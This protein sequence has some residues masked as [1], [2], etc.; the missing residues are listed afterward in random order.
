M[1]RKRQN[2]ISLIFILGFMG[3]APKS[4]S[5]VFN[6]KMPNLQSKTQWVDSIMNQ[7]TIDQKIGQLMM[8]R[9]HSDKSPAYEN[10]VANLV[11]NFQ[12][13]GICFFQGTPAKQ[14]A[15]TNYYQSLAN[16]P[17]MIGM[18]AEWGLGMRLTDSVMSFPKSLTLGAIKNNALIKD[19]GKEIAV[20]LKRIGVHVNFAPVADINNNPENPVINVRSFGENRENVATKATAYMQGLQENGIMACAKHFPGHGDTNIDSHFE[21]PVL[22]QTFDRLDSLELFPF[23]TLISQGIQSVM[24]GHLNVPSIESKENIPTSLSPKA[25]N[26]LLINKM[27]FKGLVFTDGLEMKGVSQLYK[28]GEIEAEALIAGNDVLLLPSNVSVAL[29]TI[30]NYMAR[31]KISESLINQK[32]RKVLEAKYNMGFSNYKPVDLFNIHDVLLSN[33]ARS[34]KRTLIE[35]AITLVRN[36]SDILPIREIDKIKVVSIALGVKNAQPFQNTVGKYI[37]SKF[38]SFDE[39]DDEEKKFQ[40]ISQCRK[41]NFVFISLHQ[42]NNN[43]KSRYGLSTSEIDLVSEISKISKVVLVNFGTPYL[44]KYF[45]NI[46][47]VIQAYEDTEDFQDLAAQILFGGATCFGNLPVTSS[48][49]SRYGLGLKIQKPIRLG[50]DIPERVGLSSIKLNTLDFLAMDAINLKATPGCQILVAKD[51]KIIFEKAYGY[52]T[53]EKTE[54][55]TSTSVYDIASITKIAATTLSVMKLQEEGK[56]NVEENI[57]KYL[58]ELACTNKE[59]LLIRDIMSHRAGL[60]SW[61]PFYEGTMI[62]VNNKRIPSPEFYS[63]TRTKLFSVKV[64]DS[65]YLTNKYREVI[66]DEIVKSELPNVGQYRYSDL[67]FY[68]LAEAISRITGKTIDKYTASTF[69]GPMGLQF[70]T[71]NP[72]NKMHR[73]RIVPSEQDNYFRLRKIQ[74]Y[75]HD[76]GAAMLGGVSGHAGL[77]SNAR[78]LTVIMQMLLNMGSYGGK[79]YL[80]PQTVRMFTS[81]CDGCNRRGLG[82]DLGVTDKNTPSNMSRLASVKTFGHTGFTGTCVWAD[83]E[84]NLIYVFL[85]NRT[86]PTMQ[87][88]KLIKED[89]RERIHTAIYESIIL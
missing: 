13:G 5:V 66:W 28:P 7:M 30:K 63:N 55:I 85:S 2:I 62:K 59:Y 35:N 87:N 12:V 27:G 64:T 38:F 50:F 34:L 22:N 45:D 44:L 8:I 76:M 69:Y 70:M 37:K 11:K 21:L 33:S 19:M 39:T 68:M 88:R 79:E 40:I 9:G 46:P 51:G 80:N 10:D 86:F 48:F 75:V 71:Y 1:L 84:N 17:L 58:E 31:G 18:D 6:K 78:D 83:P 73:K 41:K 49:K 81:K 3:I 16:V 42:L 72:L 60:R 67:G 77:F 47:F 52:Q 15:L 61:I 53:Y 20:Q 56:I 89:F 24:V 4:N 29:Q 65:L 26:E 54:P 43:S 57:S 23:S 14:A 36:Q 32:V 74:G 82:F 25:I